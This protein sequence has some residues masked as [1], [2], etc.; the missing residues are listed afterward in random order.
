MRSNQ[1]NYVPIEEQKAVIRSRRQADKTS[2]IL[3]LFNGPVGRIRPL[4][5]ADRF[6]LTTVGGRYPARTDDLLLVRQTL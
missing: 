5:A 4:L 1:L 2:L 3:G 6:L